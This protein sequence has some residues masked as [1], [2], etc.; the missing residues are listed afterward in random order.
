MDDTCEEMR[1]VS[2]RLSEGNDEI[3]SALSP[4]ANTTTPGD[5]G[6]VDGK[7]PGANSISFLTMQL[8]QEIEMHFR[9]TDGHNEEEEQV[10]SDSDGL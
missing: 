7:P 3:L 1:R 2:N 4:G 5:A 9:T 10:R 6:H 8:A